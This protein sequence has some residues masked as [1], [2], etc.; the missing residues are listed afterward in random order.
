MP[1]KPTLSLLFA[2]SFALPAA[3]QDPPRRI[4]GIDFLDDLDAALALSKQDGKPVVAYF[5]FDT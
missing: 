3:A 5:T 2:A 4:G 1:T